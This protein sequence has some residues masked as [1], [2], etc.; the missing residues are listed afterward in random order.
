ME[1]HNLILRE[2]RRLVAMGREVEA[3]DLLPNPLETDLLRAT[4]EM[5]GIAYDILLQAG[6][7]PSLRQSLA[8]RAASCAGTPWCHEQELMDSFLK[9]PEEGGP[10]LR[11]AIPPSLVAQAY[12]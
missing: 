5:N 10:D 3:L 2:F 11:F 7:I 6:K 4:A 12:A 9:T 8:A 1:W